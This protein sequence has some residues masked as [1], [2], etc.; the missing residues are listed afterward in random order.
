MPLDPLDS[1][2]T[3]DPIPPP[4]AR[5]LR[6]G[7]W[8][9]LLLWSVLATGIYGVY[10]DAIHIPP[11]LNP[12]APLDV[13]A[14]PGLLTRYKLSRARSDPARCLAALENTGMQYDTLPDR[15]TGEG[16]GFQNAVRLRAAAVRMGAPFPLSCP[17]ALSFFMRERHALQPAAQKHMGQRV[18]GIDH[19]GSY[20]CR[21]VNR[22]EGAQPN[23]PARARSRHAT[24]NALDISA[25][26]LADGQRI[27]VLKDWAGED[28]AVPLKPKEMLL[29]EAHDGAC[30]YFKGALG[31]DYNAVHKDHFHLETGGYSMCR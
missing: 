8:L 24:A 21:N 20:A 28:A 26:T 22:G 27:T 30:K 10:T 18:A 6:W 9:A 31:P 2:P 11:Q 23:A 1:P 13:M 7:R 29:R 14:Q 4:P 25:F 15:S 19:L 16:C 3:P 12:W 5:P 17:M